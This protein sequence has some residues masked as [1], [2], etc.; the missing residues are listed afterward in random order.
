MSGADL[1]VRRSPASDIS[2]MKHAKALDKE[3]NRR[4]QYNYAQVCVNLYGCM[5]A[6][7]PMNM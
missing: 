5:Y 4:E 1:P 6:Y 2:L 7:I 3:I